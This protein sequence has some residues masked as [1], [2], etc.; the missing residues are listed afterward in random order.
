MFL[1][2][3]VEL[4]TAVLSA[5]S[6]ILARAQHFITKQGLPQKIITVCSCSCLPVTGLKYHI[7]SVQE[8]GFLW[9]WYLS[10]Q[11][12]DSRCC[13]AELGNW[14]EETEPDR[15]MLP[16]SCRGNTCSWRE[17]ER[18]KCGI[19][20][21][22]VGARKRSGGVE[23]KMA[24]FSMWDRI[25]FIDDH[26]LESYNYNSENANI[27][28]VLGIFLCHLCPT[29]AYWCGGSVICG[30]MSKN[31]HPHPHTPTAYHI[32]LICVLVR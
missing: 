6:H 28:S 15:N 32:C 4:L 1:C 5:L 3:H 20:W 13:A 26:L 8:Q 29:K 31:N 23:L 18:E 12:D 17:G 7:I 24:D 22:R 11:R 9:F 25:L 30:M 21:K 14:P 2:Q 19:E 10:G 27:F 16:V